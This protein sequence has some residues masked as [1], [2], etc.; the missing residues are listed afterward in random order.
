MGVFRRGL[1]A[2]G[3]VAILLLLGNAP[4]WH[5]H[6]QPRHCWNSSGERRVVADARGAEGRGGQCAGWLPGLGTTT[7]PAEPI[8]RG[9]G[10]VCTLCCPG[11]FASRVMPQMS[12][13][14]ARSRAPVWIL[15]HA[16]TSPCASQK[17]ECERCPSLGFVTPEG[18]RLMRK[19]CPHKSLGPSLPTQALLSCPEQQAPALLP[20]V[21]F[22]AGHRKVLPVGS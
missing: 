20:V 13:R 1:W 6:P 12:M 18:L 15:V 2:R 21:L 17:V 22:I 7:V 10:C 5:W 4:T 14:R 16:I 9:A 3:A 8:S 11:R 19:S